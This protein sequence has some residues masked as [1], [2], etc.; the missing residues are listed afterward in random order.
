MIEGDNKMEQR[1]TLLFS[2]LFLVATC[3]WTGAWALE[4]GDKAPDFTLP[5]TTG[6]N[7]SLSDFRGKKIVLLEFYGADFSPVWAKNL[8]ARKVDYEKFKALNVQILGISANNPFS[9]NVFADSLKLPYPLLSDFPHLKTINSYGGLSRELKLT[10]AQR[11]FFLVDRDGIIRGQWMGNTRDV[12]NSEP[13]L[14]VARQIAEKNQ[15]QS[16]HE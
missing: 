9:Q 3:G 2:V 11:W 15:P 1:H 8:L 5:S 13:I 10:V 6:K 16:G 7:V 4:V 14:E 12:Q